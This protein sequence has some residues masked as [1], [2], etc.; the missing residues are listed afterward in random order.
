MVA[1]GLGELGDLQQRGLVGIL[2]DERN[3]LRLDSGGYTKYT[4]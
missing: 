1:W 3:V 2:G 4:Y